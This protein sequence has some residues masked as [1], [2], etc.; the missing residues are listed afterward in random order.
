MI[1]NYTFYMMGKEYSEGYDRIFGHDK[2][3]KISSRSV[4]S[5]GKKGGKKRLRLRQTGSQK[6]FEGVGSDQTTSE[7]CS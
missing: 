7:L 3:K 1:H 2:N 4:H 5:Q 6:R